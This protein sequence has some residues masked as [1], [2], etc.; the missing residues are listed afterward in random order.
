MKY[1]AVDSN[2]EKHEI[3]VRHILHD[4]YSIFIDGVWNSLLYCLSHDVAFRE[5]CKRNNLKPTSKLNLT[6]STTSN[7][8]ISFNTED[9]FTAL[10]MLD[11]LHKFEIITTSEFET[12]KTK[13]IT[14][15]TK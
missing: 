8:N 7:D 1:Y 13:V 10:T 12:L 4:S 11:K 15:Y 2:N 9:C 6:Q 3:V 5:Y 14:L